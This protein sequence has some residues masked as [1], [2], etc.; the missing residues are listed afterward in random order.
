[1]NDEF[2]AKWYF[3]SLVNMGGPMPDGTRAQNLWVEEPDLVCS[4]GAMLSQGPFKGLPQ[5]NFKSWD[6]TQKDLW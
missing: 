5:K 2:I 1:V 6:Y 4:S 3:M